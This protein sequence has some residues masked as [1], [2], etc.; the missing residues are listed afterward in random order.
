M[1]LTQSVS[2]SAFS[3]GME[4]VCERG[5][6]L[7]SGNARERFFGGTG[8]DE[9]VRAGKN[10]LYL[11]LHSRGFVWFLPVFLFSERYFVLIEGFWYSS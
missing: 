4:A 8:W 1:G 6:V 3:L 2:C 5:I 10:A 7:F 11:A 9:S